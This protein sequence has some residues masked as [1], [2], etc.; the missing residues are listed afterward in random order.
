MGKEREKRVEMTKQLK[1]EVFIAGLV[2]VLG[3]APPVGAFEAVRETFNVRPKIVAKQ[4]H[5]TMK[6]L[7]GVP[8]YQPNAPIEP[9]FVVANVPA[10]FF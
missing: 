2:R 9:S 7:Q 4:W 5:T 1:K 3:G 8:A 6:L 10:D